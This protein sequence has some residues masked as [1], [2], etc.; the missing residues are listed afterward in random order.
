LSVKI[1]DP[2]ERA[3]SRPG[4]NWHPGDFEFFDSQKAMKKVRRNL[5]RSVY[6]FN[7]TVLVGALR[8]MRALVSEQPVHEDKVNLVLCNNVTTEK[9]WIPMTSWIM[10]HRL[11]HAMATGDAVGTFDSTFPRNQGPEFELFAGLDDVWTEAYGVHY[12]GSIRAKYIKDGSF[13]CFDGNR[14]TI[15]FMANWL[16][17]MKS[18]RDKL[19]SNELDIFAEAFAQFLHTGR[20][21]LKKWSESGIEELGHTK[22]FK[23]HPAVQM[24]WGYGADQDLT[25]RKVPLERLDEM[26]ASLE[27]LVNERMAI[28]ASR[29]IGKT[30]SF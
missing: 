23:R 24:D 10:F 11:S 29:M 12:Q 22:N 7:V 27:D 3:R 6:P 2:K 1:I 26:L 21:R 25:K 8:D 17:T 30:F 9:N 4:G 19:I 18:A 16:F 28:L 20:F 13:T 14:Y 15:G 5:E